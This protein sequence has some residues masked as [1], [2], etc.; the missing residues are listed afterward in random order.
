LI[1]N[2]FIWRSSWFNAAIV[3]AG[4]SLTG[5]S[6]R[7]PTSPLCNSPQVQEQHLFG[8][9]LGFPAQKIFALNKLSIEFAKA[10]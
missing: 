10:F 1:H 4:D 3:T 2:N 6:D 5:G 8:N 7:G 9:K